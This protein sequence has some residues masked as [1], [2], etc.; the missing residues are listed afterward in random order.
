MSLLDSDDIIPILSAQNQT[1]LSGTEV[2]PAVEGSTPI[3]FTVALL[4]AYVAS[5]HDHNLQYAAID[6]THESSEIVNSQ[7]VV[8]ADATLLLSDVGGTVYVTNETPVTLTLL[9]QAKTAWPEEAIIAIVGKGPGGVNLRAEDLDLSINGISGATFALDLGTAALLQLGEDPNIWTLTDATLVAVAP[10]VAE[11]SVDSSGTVLTLRGSE[12]LRGTN[13]FAFFVGGEPYALSSPVVEQGVI[14]FAI[15]QVYAGQSFTLSYSPGDVASEITGFPMAAFSPISVQDTVDEPP[16]TMYSVI[17]IGDW[18]VLNGATSPTETNIVFPGA[19]VAEQV[20][21][22]SLDYINLEDGETWVVEFSLRD[23]SGAGVSVVLQLQEDIHFVTLLEKTVTLSGEFETYILRGVVETTDPVTQGFVRIRNG[24][25][26]AKDI[27]VNLVRAWKQADAGVPV[28]TYGYL[29]DQPPDNTTRTLNVPWA[30]NG[31]PLICSGSLKSAPTAAQLACFDII[32]YK[33]FNDSQVAAAQAINPDAGFIRIWC[34]QEY[35]GWNDNPGKIGNG[36]PFDTTGATS[37]GTGAMFAGHWLYK[38]FTTLSAGINSSTL[39]FTVSDGGRIQVGNYICIHNGSF[40]A[41]EFM[42]VQRVTGNSIT[43]NARGYKSTAQSHNSGDRVAQLQIG[44]G[45]GD[46]R[47]WAYNLSMVC[48][49]DGAG[50][51]FNETLSE[52]YAANYLKDTNGDAAASTIHG[53]LFDSDFYQFVKGGTVLTRGCDIDN[54]GVADGGMLA[55]GTNTWGVGLVWFMENLRAELD[56]LGSPHNQK[57]LWIGDAHNFGI[58]S[59][60]NG[61]FEGWLSDVL[62][63]GGTTEPKLDHYSEYIDFVKVNSFGTVGPLIGDCQNKIRTKSYYAG[64]SAPADDSFHRMCAAMATI[65]GQTISHMNS[66]AGRFHWFDDYAVCT[67]TSDPTYSYGQCIPASDTSAILTYKNWLGDPAGNWSRVYGTEF[68]RSAAVWGNPCESLVGITKTSDVT[69]SLSST[70]PQQGSTCLSVV[71]TNPD[72][73]PRKTYVEIP[74]EGLVSG[75]DYTLCWSMRSTVE[76]ELIVQIANRGSRFAIPG[77]GQWARK[78]FCF[79]P[80]F[81]ANKLSLFIGG[82]G[83]SF[84]LDDF[85][86]FRGAADVFKREFQNGIVLANCT[87]SPSPVIELG[88]SYHHING[89]QDRTINDGRQNVT[90]VTLSS[91]NGAFLIKAL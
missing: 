14:R 10:T 16:T 22:T 12:P 11:A 15:P 77:G 71:Q 59:C 23:N 76:R 85:L 32:N 1:S 17:D 20:R 30:D 84:D 62:A 56:A 70:S 36:I 79:R 42:K 74:I 68:V 27:E 63:A 7:R 28:L 33:I 60:C 87:R 91:L 86:L 50:K 81:S 9:K 54:D 3:R 78:V 5:N 90:T 34:P 4:R 49:V 47:N 67:S 80:G 73:E 44:N 45:G 82:D 83:A 69:L 52:F 21:P 61:Q 29:E 64:P 6:H 2:V 39:T 75:E 72:W 24:Q 65:L 38:P 18:E 66:F 53:I 37:N 19:A 26:V 35:Q 48:P 58:E 25:T 51:R 13:G 88:G 41:A 8:S 40:G 46:T 31:Y 89:Q 43:V 57:V 55:N